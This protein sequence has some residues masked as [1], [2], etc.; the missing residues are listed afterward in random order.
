MKLLLIRHGAT[1]GNLEHRYIGC[2]DEPLAPQGMTTLQTKHYPACEVLAV[3][4]L[5]RCVQT[6]EI[7]F[8]GQE[9]RL[10]PD[11]RECDFGRFEGKNYAELNGDPVYQSWIDSGGTAS[12][13]DGETPAA[14]QAR[15]TAAFSQL[16]RQCTGAESL[17]IVAHG[18]TMMS[19]LSA[20]DGGDYFS[21][22][23]PN[24]AAYV[25]EF[26]EDSNLIKG[27]ERL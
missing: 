20:Y 17:A 27:L 25:C 13:P 5:R 6:A 23:M 8:P 15:C 24:G 19:I 2:T 9:M 7:L 4:P 3:S 12:F 1:Q 26:A 14:F 21:Y 22:Q 10:C 11:F 18:G 16:V